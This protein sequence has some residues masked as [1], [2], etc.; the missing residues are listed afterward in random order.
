MNDAIKNVVKVSKW[1]KNGYLERDY[2]Y[3]TKVGFIKSEYE[4]PRLNL[5][6][7]TIDKNKMYGGLS[8]AVKLYRYLAEYLEM[9]MR[10]IMTAESIKSEIMEQYPD[11]VCMESGQDSDAHKTVC[12]VD[13]CNHSRGNISVRK[14]D[15]FM[16]TYWSTFYIIAD[17]LKFQKEKYGID[18]KLLYLIQDYEPGFYQWSTE[19]LLTDS[20]YKYGNTVAI[21][22]S[23]NL[24]NYFK[25]L[26]YKFDE[27]VAFDPKLN[28]TL[29]SYLHLTD[30]I[31]RK[32]RV[33]IYGR[34]N[35]ARNSFLMIVEALNKMIEKY[36]PD[37][38]WEYLSI[39]G[40]HK[41]IKLKN[42]NTL[43][44]GGKLTLEKYAEILAESSVGVSLMCSPHP[45]YPPLEMAAFGVQ[46]VTNS[47]LCKD[48]SSFSENI[49]SLDIV[50]FDTVADAIY[51]AMQ[52]YVERKPVNK[53]SEYLNLENQFV[54]V[55]ESVKKIVD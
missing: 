5:V 2:E 13:V 11:F 12:T 39:G 19:F 26:D 14:K 10:I 35:V 45:S 28:E 15:I 17:V 42:G 46:T 47:F 52:Q 33:I 44:A 48:L 23:Q 29:L 43:V 9:D 24:M 53:E 54:R 22:N 7:S 27:M 1:M 6:I 34:P 21:F 4:N 3:L 20:T 25:K 31:K 55:G 16:A 40:N 51:A 18:N 37:S 50:N 49:H 32:K 38:E 8:T 41:S 30:K 36:N